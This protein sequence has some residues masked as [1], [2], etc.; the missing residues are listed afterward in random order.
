MSTHYFGLLQMVLSEHQ[1]AP[2]E[3]NSKSPK[4]WMEL[5]MSVETTIK[6]ESHACI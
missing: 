2:T 4:A 1:V 5:E 6:V 3:G